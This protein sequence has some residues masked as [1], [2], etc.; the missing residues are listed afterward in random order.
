MSETPEVKLIA[1]AL[2]RKMFHARVQDCGRL[3]ATILDLQDKLEYPYQDDILRSVV[4]GELR[5]L[6]K[7]T[8]VDLD[9]IA[10]EGPK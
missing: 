6:E 9:A 1:T 10:A 5:R 3:V 7:D 8:G 4:D 2:Y